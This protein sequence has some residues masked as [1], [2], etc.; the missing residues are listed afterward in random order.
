MA[1]HRSSVTHKKAEFSKQT[2]GP[3]PAAKK[4][5][6]GNT[7]K[8]IRA[9]AEQVMVLR[10]IREQLV[11]SQREL[12]LASTD[13]LFRTA[14]PAETI[15]KITDA[16]EM[17]K[18]ERIRTFFARVA[19]V[20]RQQQKVDRGFIVNVA[21]QMGKYLAEWRQHQID[22]V[23]VS[24][25]YLYDAFPFFGALDPG[26]IVD[27]KDLSD[28][29]L[30]EKMNEAFDELIDNIDGAITNI[31]EEDIDP[32]DLP[33]SVA[34]TKGSLNP[35]MQE[36]LAEAMQEHE[37]EKFWINLGLT[38]FQAAL[39]FVPVVGPL[40]AAGAGLA[41][42]G[43]D[44]EDVLDRR[45]MSKA[46]TAPDKTLLG[47]G[48]PSNFEWAMVA[49]Q[50][51]LTAAD[52]KGAWTAIDGAR[53][54]FGVEPHGTPHPAGAPAP[55]AEP[56]DPGVAPGKE[57]PPLSN[58]DKSLLD[59]SRGVAS[60]DLTPTQ[61]NTETAAVANSPRRQPTMAG[62]VEEVELPNGHTWRKT[63]EGRW[64]RY[65]NGHL[66]FNF[67]ESLEATAIHETGAS[68]A[69]I[70]DHDLNAARRKLRD[71]L[72]PAPFDDAQGHH[73]V[74]LELRDHPLVGEMHRLH[75][76]DINGAGN[77]IYLPEKA[78]APGAGALPVHSGSHPAYTAW[79][80]SR[81]S[82][83]Y[84]EW[85]LGRIADD[86]IYGR[87]LAVVQEFH[88]RLAGTKIVLKP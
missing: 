11:D 18:S 53:P 4:D 81:M 33:Q 29:K 40:L 65:S 1:A 61:L 35:A 21:Y 39:I 22:G 82:I 46:S 67:G 83:L 8:A 57:P 68:G 72:G 51:A 26:D 37:V 52:L 49:V 74:P 60:A 2:S 44:V 84:Q 54:K 32:F 78:S 75:G 41:Q 12:E 43:M 62:Y 47:V 6:V 56:H 71:N 28:A 66:C 50:V 87:F 20:M 36:V 13:L 88:G 55:V 63:P 73:V 25:V 76:W 14:E 42:I 15:K 77:G 24:L 59:E 17:Y 16:A 3:T 79:V 7:A 38:L 80:E 10:H 69:G 48:G 85:T 23:D 64:C 30:I 19:R 34:A 86:Q 31:G 45:G 5:A 27:D 70:T 9:S 58:L